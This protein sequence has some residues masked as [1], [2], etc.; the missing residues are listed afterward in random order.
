MTFKIFGNTL[1]GFLLAAPFFL[2]LP[3]RDLAIDLNV[4]ELRPVIF[5]TFPRVI[6][7]S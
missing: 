2:G 6:F 5:W 3:I 1:T 7:A 4:S